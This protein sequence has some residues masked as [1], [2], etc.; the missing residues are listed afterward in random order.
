MLDMRKLYE[1]LMG[2]LHLKVEQATASHKLF[3]AV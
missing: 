2:R 3:I 1:V